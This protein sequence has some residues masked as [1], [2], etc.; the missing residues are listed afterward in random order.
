MLGAVHVGVT[1]IYVWHNVL[2]SGIVAYGTYDLLQGT[3]HGTTSCMT[4]NWHN[5][6]YKM[7]NVQLKPF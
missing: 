2:Y 7:H 4:I 1:G 5:I 6:Y 3:V